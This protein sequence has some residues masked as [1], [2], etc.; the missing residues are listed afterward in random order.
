MNNELEEDFFT[1][2][3]ETFKDILKQIVNHSSSLVHD[4]IGLV[5]QELRERLQDARAGAIILGVGFV[6]LLVATITLS[7]AVVIGLSYYIAPGL[8]ALIT[9]V[10][11]GLVGLI[12]VLNGIKMLKEKVGKPE[13]VLEH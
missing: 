3:R 5:K 2:K 1:P 7:A 12:A 9:G 4:E 8:A 10:V 13:G 6:F 11:L